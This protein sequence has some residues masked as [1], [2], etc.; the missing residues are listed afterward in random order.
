MFEDG[1]CEHQEARR[2]EAA[3]Q[4]VMVPESLLQRMQLVSIGEPFDGP[5][6]CAFR[7]HRKHQARTYR[8]VLY[9]YRAS[10]THAVLA[11]EMRARE[12]ALLAQR[13]G[14]CAAGIGPRRS[15]GAL[16]S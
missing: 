9:Q 10:A 12:A 13:I 14:Q 3:L 7:L 15:L 5:D 11:A 4:S 16:C 8:L 1:D 6:A 2:A